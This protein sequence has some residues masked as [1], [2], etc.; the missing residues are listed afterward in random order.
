MTVLK[1][2]LKILIAPVI[3]L[4]TLTIWICVGLVYVS[5]LV[6][7]LVSM[8]FVMLVITYLFSQFGL[9]KLV[10]WSFGH[11][12]RCRIFDICCKMQLIKST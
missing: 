2:I 3:L 1:L 7:S 5:G 8:V 9:P 11:L 10:F 12:E 6:L 4:I